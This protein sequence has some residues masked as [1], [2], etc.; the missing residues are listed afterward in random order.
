MRSQNGQFN[1]NF[2]N[3]AISILML[4]IWVLPI[5]IPVLIVWVHNLSVRWNTAFSSHH[6]LLSI[7]PIVLLVERMITGKMIPRM[8][9]RFQI[10]TKILLIYLIIYACLHGILN[11]YW[12]HYIVNIFSFWLFIVYLDLGADRVMFGMNLRNCFDGK[13]DKRP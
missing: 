7:M 2:S 10:I 12:L 1:M 8:T 11:A 6:N 4:M 13:F 9:G 3:F 5:N